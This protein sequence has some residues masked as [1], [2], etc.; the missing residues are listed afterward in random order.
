M[1]ILSDNIRLLL[2][3]FI[4]VIGIVSC[5]EDMEETTSVEVAF[6][7]TLQEEATT[8]AFG[9]GLNVNILVVGI[10][11][12]E[13]KH[14]DRK[15]FPIVESSVNIRLTLAKGQT[16]N[17]VFWAY[18]SECEVYDMSDLTAIKM[19]NDITNITLTQVENSDAFFAT[20]RDF[21]VA[22]SMVTEVE[23]V[24][25]LAQINVGT[26]G[27]SAKVSFIVKNTADTFH[28]FTGAVSGET[29]FKWTFEEITNET[30]YVEGTSY[31]YLSMCYIFAP[32]GGAGN[33]TKACELVLK[34]TEE[35]KDF[36]AVELHANYRTNIVGDFTE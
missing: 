28:P 24:R 6:A 4:L 10:Y 31:T 17:F 13:Q 16:Y 27:T 1:E 14:I 35:K 20:I 34:D 7:A 29:D 12:K 22:E 5:S 18:S 19:R 26:S 15:A 32:S 33:M 21:K 30:L 11:D 25:P 23:L 3:P 8:R 36:P 2:L 9:E